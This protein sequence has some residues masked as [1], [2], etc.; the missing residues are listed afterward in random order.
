MYTILDY[1]ITLA[2]FSKLILLI[3]TTSSGVWSLLFNIFTVLNTIRFGVIFQPDSCLVV[4]PHCWYLYT[5][6][7]TNE[8]E[9]MSTFSYTIDLSKYL[10]F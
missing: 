6:P 7:V 2:C 5:C 4:S 9:H 3:Y 8:I 10:L 1:W